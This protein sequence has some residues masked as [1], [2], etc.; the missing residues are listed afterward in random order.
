MYI[1]IHWASKETYHFFRA[2]LTKIHSIKINHIWTQISFTALILLNKNI[3]NT[4]DILASKRRKYG[5]ITKGHFSKIAE[6]AHRASSERAPRRRPIIKFKRY[7]FNFNGGLRKHRAGY[8]L[9]RT[10]G[11]RGKQ[12]LRFFKTDLL[13]FHP[14]YLF[15]WIKLFFFFTCAY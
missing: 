11:P 1:Y 6:T 7:S 4:Q 14:I 15:D 2:T 12:F 13:R 8:C 5:L 9:L 10:P 3:R